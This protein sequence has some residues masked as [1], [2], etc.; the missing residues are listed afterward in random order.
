[1]TNC[2][3]TPNQLD[4][5]LIPRDISNLSFDNQLKNVLSSSK[6]TFRRQVMGFF[7]AMAKARKDINRG[8]CANGY[9]V[10][11]NAVGGKIF[12]GGKSLSNFFDRY[13]AAN[14]SGFS[15]LLFRIV[16]FQYRQAKIQSLK[17]NGKYC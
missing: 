3:F 15:G 4:R 13:L 17:R 9:R 5:L 11:W 7:V 2:T 10:T 8:S 12:I 6:K 1:M 14:R 16:Q